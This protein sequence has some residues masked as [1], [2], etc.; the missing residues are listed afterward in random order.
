MIY[1]LT[2]ELHIFSDSPFSHCSALTFPP[3]SC[4]IP[5]YFLIC[6]DSS[7]I[8]SGREEGGRPQISGLMTQFTTLTTVLN[9]SYPRV[10]LVTDQEFIHSLVFSLRGRG[11]RNQSPVMWP[12]WLWHTASWASSWG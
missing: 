9:N 12:V 4:T 1:F 11:G 5:H 2:S 8:S 10:T 6:L 7:Y 3:A